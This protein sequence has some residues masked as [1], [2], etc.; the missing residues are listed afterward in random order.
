MKTFDFSGLNKK[1]PVQCHN[2]P[3]MFMVNYSTDGPS[4]ISIV[5]PNL[6]EN[7]HY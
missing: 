5:R 3:H 7:K 6:D 4:K 1:N 2:V